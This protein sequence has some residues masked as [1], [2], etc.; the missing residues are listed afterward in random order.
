M[1]RFFERGVEICSCSIFQDGYN[2]NVHL[3]HFLLW[4]GGEMA[5]AA[6]LKSAGVKLRVGSTPTRPTFSG[7]VSGLF[8]F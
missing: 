1:T 8:Y 4:G 2:T 5:D 7:P 6:D 3:L